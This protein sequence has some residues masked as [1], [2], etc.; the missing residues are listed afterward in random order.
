MKTTVTKLADTLQ[1]NHSL[2]IERLKVD[3]N[4]VEIID[5]FDAAIQFECDRSLLE[6]A[7]K[8]K[9]IVLTTQQTLKYLGLSSV[10]KLNKLGFPSFIAGRTSEG[11]RYLKSQVDAHRKTVTMP[12]APQDGIRHPIRKSKAAYLVRLDDIAHVCKCH[13]RTILRVLTAEPNPYWAPGHNPEIDVFALALML[14]VDE[15]VLTDAIEGSDV[16]L[17]QEQA[18]AKLKVPMRTFRYRQRSKADYAPAIS[19]G[20]LVRYSKKAISAASK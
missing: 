2:V 7:L 11:R 10:Q 12:E 4:E 19:H 5:S 15:L 18:A 6:L 20:H 16:L 17:T 3:P 9:D 8:E 1:V 13:P 14:G